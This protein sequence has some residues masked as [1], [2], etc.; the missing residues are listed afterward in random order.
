[1]AFMEVKTATFLVGEEGFNVET[2]FIPIAGF[3][4]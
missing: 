4:G 3:I 1:M 2:F